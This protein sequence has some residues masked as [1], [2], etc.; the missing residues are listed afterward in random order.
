MSALA[1]LTSAISAGNATAENNALYAGLSGSFAA[2]AAA[3]TGMNA[4]AIIAAGVTA[5]QP[6]IA[7]G[8]SASPTPQ[9]TSSGSDSVGRLEIT[10]LAC[11][12]AG[13]ILGLAVLAA[14]PIA[15]MR[16]RRRR[17]RVAVAAGP[18][19]GGVLPPSTVFVALPESHDV[20]VTDVAAARHAGDPEGATFLRTVTVADV[21]AVAARREG[22]AFD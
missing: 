1:A 16:G 7:S 5:S 13:G 19:P 20:A 6:A 4:G 17:A 22:S 11:G 10:Y 12:I 15:C 18:D 2:A 21:T 14:L 8:P 9:A 3:A